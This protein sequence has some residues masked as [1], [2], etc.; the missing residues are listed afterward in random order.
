MDRRSSCPT[1]RQ[2]HDFLFQGMLTCSYCGCAVVAEIK[3]GKYVYYHCTGNRGKCPGKYA[4]EE[5]I[6]QQFAQSLGQI[7]I[8]DDVMKWIVTV[9]KQSTAEGR[10]QKEG[11]LK[12]LTKT[13]QLQEDRLEKM[14]LDKLDGTISED[15]YKRLSNKFREELTDIKFRMEECRQEK[16][17]SIDSA[18]RL[19]ELAQKASSLYLGQVPG[20]KRELLNYV[21][22][23]STFGSGELKANFRKPFDM[24]AESNCEYQRKKA[25]SLA[26]NDLF[27]IWRPRDDSNVR[28]LP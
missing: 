8:D 27:D 5:L 24:L 21:Y 17:E 28:P 4:R 13:K 1:G 15:E 2:T 3:K 20:E 10:K 19:L 25:T 9:M 6:D 22:S 23:N 11:Q 12:V 7:R 16:G 18:A 14:Y 26:K